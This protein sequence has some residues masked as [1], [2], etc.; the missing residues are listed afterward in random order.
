MY[1]IIR[2]G[3][4]KFYT[5]MVFGYYKS[6]DNSDYKNRFWIV[7]NKAKTA[8][9]KQHVLQQNTQYLIPM[10]LITDADES[11]WN[12]ISANEE[13]AAFLPTGKL[14]SLIDN[15]AVPDEL[16]RKC[17]DMDKAYSFEPIRSINGASDIRDFTWVSGGLHDA[18]IAEKKEGED[19]LYLLF[20]GTWGCKIEVWFEGDVSYDTSGRD[21]GKWDPY[22][23]GSTVTMENGFVYLMDEEDVLVQDIRPEHCWFRARTMKYRVIP[24]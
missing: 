20:D 21:S 7:L 10:V 18:Y 4:G 5:S 13:S 24:D 23:F 8:L 2:E 1:A 14:L 6:S 17:I 19:A 3:D 16:T 22:W 11:G 15:D 9:I 12:K